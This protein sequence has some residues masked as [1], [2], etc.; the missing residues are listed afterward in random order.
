MFTRLVQLYESLG[1]RDVAQIAVLAV[2]LFGVLRFLGRTCGAGSSIG[3]GLGLV[4]VG[5]FLLLQVVMANLDLTALSTVLDY[6]L[7]TV[8][9]GMLVLFQPELRRGLMMLGQ[10][11]FWRDRVHAKHA[12]ADPLAD[13][14]E[15]MSR[16]GVGALIAVQREVSLEPYAESGQRIDGLLSA[17]LIRNLFMPKSP[18]HDGAVIIAHGRI[19]A[20]GCQLPLRTHQEE[21]DGLIRLHSMGMR[22]RAALCLSE[23]SDAVVLVVSEETGR[24]S[25]AVAGRFEPVPRENLAR[26]LADLLSAPVQRAA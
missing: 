24:A 6:L 23:D 5:L 20:A 14:A 1:V 17:A 22:H 16:D 11:K 8:L 26:R 10:T 2:V 7:T 12:L 9:F 13:A 15:A 18:L 19:V 21:E 25:L 4:F 3:R